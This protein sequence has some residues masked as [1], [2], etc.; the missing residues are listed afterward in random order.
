MQKME[1]NFFSRYQ[2]KVAIEVFGQKID[3]EEDEEIVS[4]KNDLEVN[5]KISSSEVEEKAGGLSI[6]AVSSNKTEQKS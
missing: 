4:P 3:E 5:K 1:Q 2:E 6:R